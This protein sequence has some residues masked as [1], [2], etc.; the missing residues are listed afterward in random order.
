VSTS[1]EEIGRPRWDGKGHRLEVWYSTFTNPATGEGFWLHYETVAPV[2]GEPYAHGWAAV[3]PP[4]GP[5]RAERFG[6][7]PV[8]GPGAASPEWFR[9]GDAVVDATS[10]VGRAG[11]LSWDL[12]YKDEA[13]PLFTFPKWSWEREILPASQVVPFPTATIEGTFVDG[14]RTVQLS[15]ARGNLARIYG[16]GNAERWAW[17]H[18]DLGGGDVCEVVTA[19]ANRPGMRRLRPVSF[20]ADRKS[21]V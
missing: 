4:D 20:V 8:G 9:A 11:D 21:V 13:P 2:E 6:P 19:V 5:A 15:G 7:L 1:P 18:A 17:L 3:F 10:M 16:H 12:R 14:G